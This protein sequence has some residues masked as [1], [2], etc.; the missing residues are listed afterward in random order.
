[1]S[2]GPNNVHDSVL[3]T[4]ILDAAV[5]AIIVSDSQGIV[6]RVNQAACDLFD[7]SQDELV[8]ASVNSLMPVAL[9][10][11]HDRFINH[12][13]E[14]GE[15]RI[16]DI[17]REVEGQ[18]KDGSIFPMHLS[19]GRADIEGSTR[20]IAIMHDLTRRRAT[21]EALARS[22]RLDA[23]GQMT[24]GLTHDFNNLLTVMIGN[25][26]LLEMR[27]KDAEHK[28]LIG[29]ALEAAEMGADLTSRL[30]MF[31]RQG[32]LNPE[33]V[34]LREICKSAI[35]LLKRTLGP[36]YNI[37][38]QFD[39][40]VDKVQIDPV[41]MQSCLI[42]L[43]MNARDA[44]PNGGDLTFSIM[45][46]EIDDTYIAQETD[47]AE[48][49]YV[50]LSVAD[51]GEGM[52]AEAQRRAF[53][54]FYSTKASG[55]GTGLGLAMVYG[56]ARQ[57]GGH[58]TLYSEVGH[59]SVVSLYFPAISDYARDPATK[60]EPAPVFGSGQK[61]LVVEDDPQVRKLSMER[62]S[63]LG[64]E[65]IEAE[66]GDVAYDLLKSGTRV[67]LI[68]T[69]LMMPGGL[70]GYSLAQ[71]VRLEFPDIPVLLTSGYA[72]DLLIPDSGTGPEFYLLR[73]PYRQKDLA[74]QLH[75]LLAGS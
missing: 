35:G 16:I 4:A 41:Q 3:L 23:I 30:L 45:N 62:I 32:D 8:G 52:G 57:S 18:R 71:R 67:D 19:V 65:A 48:G 46:I 26:E 20:F 12:H 58:V 28:A 64:L 24:G 49:S 39:A 5:D 33:V 74:D 31:A 14:T 36:L 17:G 47:I 37:D 9:G 2:S 43:V 50:R 7:F 51:T 68:F 22:T 40:E 38:L 75:A 34:D 25:L 21:E 42:N 13:L 11:A 27:T 56:F 1:M 55:K 10:Q 70:N 44:M 63:S 15:K 60:P 6:I 29:D 61:V 73:K 53:E 69:D 54:P 66:T 72:S 59:G